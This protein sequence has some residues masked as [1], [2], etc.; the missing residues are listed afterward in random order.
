MPAGGYA[1]RRVLQLRLA[2]ELPLGPVLAVFREPHVTA[3]IDRERAN[4]V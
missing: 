3:R 1:A 2:N 4:P